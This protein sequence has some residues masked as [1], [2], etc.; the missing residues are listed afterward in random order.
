MCKGTRNIFVKG[1]VHDVQRIFNE[2]DILLSSSTTEGLPNSVLEALSNNIP[3]ILSD[4]DQHNEIYEGI[5]TLKNLIFKNNKRIELIKCIK[6]LIDNENDVRANMKKVIKN[7]SVEKM[8][9]SYEDF[10]NKLCTNQN[11]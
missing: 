4:I 1:H 5:D 6:Y 7:F 11:Y 10:Y 8:V 9:T 3:C 2:T